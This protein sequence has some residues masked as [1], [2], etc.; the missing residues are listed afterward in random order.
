MLIVLF[1][2]G[3]AYILGRLRS[4]FYSRNFSF[5]TKPEGQP[6]DDAAARRPIPAPADW[7]AKTPN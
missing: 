7:T 6:T 4:T 3:V 2:G 5:E 1:L